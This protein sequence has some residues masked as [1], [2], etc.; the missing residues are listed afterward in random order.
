MSFFIELQDHSEV[1]LSILE[2]YTIPWMRKII[3]NRYGPK[4]CLLIDGFAG[5]GK[6]DNDKKGSPLIMIEAAIDFYNQAINN[7]WNEPE[8]FIYLNE[9]DK[10]NHEALISN[11]ESI[12]FETMDNR[13]FI[14]VDYKSVKVVVENKTFE[15]FLT[16]I[17]GQIKDGYSLIPSFCFVD[18]F[19]FSTTPFRLFKKYLDNENSELLINFMYEHTNR[20]IK[21]P[22]EKVR[23]QISEHMGL[24]SLDDLSEKITD[25]TPLERKQIIIETYI[26]N[27]L[28]ETKA[29][30]VRHFDIKKNG[31]TKMILFHATKNINGLKLMKETMWK[32]DETGQYIYDDK[33]QMVQ[34]DFDTIIK[35]D[36]EANI[37]ILSEL[38][39]K[40][41]TGS[42]AV[43]IEEIEKFTLIDTIYPIKN[44]TKPALKVLENKGLIENFKGRAKAKSYP[45]GTIMD[46]R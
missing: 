4:K 12:G 31:K 18:P 13:M 7:E 45:Q 8:I 38:I 43:C 36:K 10:S 25:L 33:Q 24:V 41:Y 29:V 2:K 30:Y 32:H 14:S 44:F 6:Y 22:N 21:H 1:K 26:N 23:K 5:K 17:L 20:F 11:I 27:I 46:F 15:D 19:G 9:L 34:L 37:S 42:K 35:N 28:K 39:Y 3:L 40:Q 16:D